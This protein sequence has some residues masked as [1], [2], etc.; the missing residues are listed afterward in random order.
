MKL[1]SWMRK[2]IRDTD[3]F[4]KSVQ[5]SYKGKTS[6]KTTFGGVVSILI[7]I[8]LTLYGILLFKEV[9]TKG[10]TT[11][12]VT[13]IVKD[14]TKDTTKHYISKGTFAFAVKLQGLYPERMLDPT[15]FKFEISQ[16][17]YTRSTNGDGAINES[18]VDIPYELWGDNFPFVEKEVYDRV[19]LQKFLCPSN[20]DHFISSNYNSEEFSVIRVQLSHCVGVGCKSKTI[21]DDTISSHF[22]EIALV[23]SYFDFDDYVSPIKTFYEDTNFFFL[24]PDRYYYNQ[25][26]V[27]PNKYESNN[28]LF[29]ESFTDKGSFYNI[30]QS[31][32]R[33][34]V[35][36]PSV[37][38]IFAYNIMLSQEYDLYERNV[39]TL[40]D[41]L[42]LLGGVYEICIIT[43][44][45][46]VNTLTKK[47]FYSSLLSNLYEINTMEY[48]E[49]EVKA[50]AT[51]KPKNNPIT[52]TKT[53]SL[54]EEI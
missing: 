38:V 29:Y 25:V 2:K 44:C 43:G 9:V 3:M 13:N 17:K 16:V 19:E 49:M 50:S 41:M 15:Y 28:N 6:F 20:T 31:L 47:L 53:S 12:S 36:K 46:L 54:T 23:N 18:F 24:N 7:K 51:V 10:N 26:K 33:I 30:G 14:L 42:G 35:Y 5:L 40:F 45:F 32:T 21:I 27:K 22:I 37:G 8:L 4:S 52:K 48:S 39:F 1:L 34:N 11:K